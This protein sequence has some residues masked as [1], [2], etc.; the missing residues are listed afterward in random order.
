[1]KDFGSSIMAQWFKYLALSQLWLWYSS[2]MGSIPGLGIFAFC[3]ATKQ[4]KK[5]FSLLKIKSVTIKS[6]SQIFVELNSITVNKKTFRKYL[7]KLVKNKCRM[8][9]EEI[10]A[11]KSLN[12]LQML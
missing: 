12:N 7:E 6:L 9:V 5:G 8:N 4:T 10:E 11:L 2:G 1:M 3:A